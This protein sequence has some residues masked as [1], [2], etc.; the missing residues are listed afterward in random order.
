MVWNSRNPQTDWKNKNTQKLGLRLKDILDAHQNTNICITWSLVNR[1]KRQRT[2][3]EEIKA[4]IFADLSKET[5]NG[6]ETM[7]V[8]NMN[9]KDELK[10]VIFKMTTNYN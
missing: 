2:L 8:P 6:Q 9:P 7:E 5:N 1:R 3:F 10:E 4:K